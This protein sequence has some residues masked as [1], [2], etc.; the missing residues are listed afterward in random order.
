MTKDY[1]KEL[2]FILFSLINEYENINEGVNFYQEEA[3][4]S[5]KEMV[6]EMV[7][8]KYGLKE[9]E[10]NVLFHHLLIDKHIISIEP[11]TIS[12][13]GIVFEGNGGY[14]EKLSQEQMEVLRIKTLERDLKK[15][16]YG[17]TLFTAI[18]AIGTLIS[19]LY[20]AVE[21]WRIFFMGK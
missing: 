11:L 12:L 18:V 13:G 16:S 1:I 4:K 9:W 3:P 20:F 2:D 6:T 19:A 17:L 15:Y 21:T 7:I 5:T 14:A 8:A 10:I